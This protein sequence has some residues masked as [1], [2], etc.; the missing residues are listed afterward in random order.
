MATRF[1][2]HADPVGGKVELD[3][4]DVTDRVA[5]LRLDM[6]A[7]EPTVLTLETRGQGGEIEGEGIVQVQSADGA[8]AFLAGIDPTTLEKAAL[9]R[10][11]WGGGSLAQLMLDQ[12]RDW[13]AGIP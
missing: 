3:G 2:I 12:L 8:G 11:Q 4:R 10:D 7:G 13:A 6:A 9:E 1:R 5:G